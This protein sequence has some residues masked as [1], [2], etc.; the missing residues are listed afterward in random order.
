[1]RFFGKFH[2]KLYFTKILTF[3]RIKVIY[4]IAE[5]CFAGRRHNQV[6]KTFLK[7]III[8]AVLFV[9]FLVA[10]KIFPDFFAG[11]YGEL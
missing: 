8:I 6:K 4:K 3:T 10:Q 7:V 2:H 5:I 1:M 11:L 9:L